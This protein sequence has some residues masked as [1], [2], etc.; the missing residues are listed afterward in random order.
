MRGVIHLVE[1]N[2]YG[3]WCIYGCIGLRQYYGYTRKEATAK[4]RAEVLEKRIV[5]GE[6]VV[7]LDDK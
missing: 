4:Y 3:A 6:S 2:R 7:Y 1:R 5:I